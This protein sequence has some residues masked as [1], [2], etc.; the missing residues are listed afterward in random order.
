VIIAPIQLPITILTIRW[1]F[2]I[3]AILSVVGF[4]GKNVAMVVYGELS[5]TK[6]Y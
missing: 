5:V 6:G 4:A 3:K 2:G 1:I